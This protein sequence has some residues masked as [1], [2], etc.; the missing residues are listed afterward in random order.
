MFFP[1]LSLHK[2][3]NAMVLARHNLGTQ[4]TALSEPAHEDWHFGIYRRPL[5]YEFSW[6]PRVIFR[7]CLVELGSSLR[8]NVRGS[9]KA[10]QGTVVNRV[11]QYSIP[12]CLAPGILKLEGLPNRES[13][14]LPEG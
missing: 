11:L 10:I 3:D 8:G 2:H 14:V 4:G 9:L 13:T 12:T 7:T 5:N 6:S 1:Q